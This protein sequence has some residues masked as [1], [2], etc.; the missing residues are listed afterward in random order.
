MTAAGETLAMLMVVAA[1]PGR[2]RGETVS[3]PGLV[4]V[5]VTVAVPPGPSRTMRLIPGP[6]S[7]S[8][9]LAGAGVPLWVAVMVMVC[10][11]PEASRL[12]LIEMAGH[13]G[14]GFEGGVGRDGFCGGGVGLGLGLVGGVNGRSRRVVADAVAVHGAVGCGVQVALAVFVVVRPADPLT[15][16]STSTATDWLGTSVPRL[17]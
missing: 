14:A 6:F 12:P 1:Q 13:P 16:T 4:G 9:V 2:P 15:A 11:R 3:M 5:T 7:S 17:Q 8:F 10:G